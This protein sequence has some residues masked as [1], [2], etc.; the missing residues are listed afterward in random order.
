MWW[1]ENMKTNKEIRI[2]RWSCTAVV[3]R[4]ILKMWRNLWQMHCY[5]IEKLWAVLTMKWE[6][7]DVLVTPDNHFSNLLI[8]THSHEHAN[9][10][11]FLNDTDKNCIACKN[12]FHIWILQWYTAARVLLIE[13]TRLLNIA[14]LCYYPRTFKKGKVNLQQ[15]KQRAWEGDALKHKR[16]LLLFDCM[17]T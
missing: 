2:P 11:V 8:H 14:L 5:D 1:N 17:G 4:L 6:T 9:G 12:R 15:Q 3:A 16:M 7:L 13:I 10:E